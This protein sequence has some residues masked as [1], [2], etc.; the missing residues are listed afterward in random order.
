VQIRHVRGVRILFASL[1]VVLA[2]TG[3]VR[4]SDDGAALYDR[5]CLACHGAKG[6]G[7]GPAAAWLWPRPRDLT[8]GERKWQD[9]DATIRWGVTGAMPGFGV[10]LDDK[11]IAALV[12]VV[13]GFAGGAP[14]KPARPKAAPAGTGDAARGQALWAEAGCTSCHGADG[15]GETAAAPY[16]LTAVPPRRPHPPGGELDATAQSIAWGVGGTAMPAYDGALPDADLLALAAYVR[17]IQPTSAPAAPGRIDPEAIAADRAGTL[18]RAGYR[19]GDA[20]DPDY[21]VWGIAIAPQG[22][23]PASLSPA[24][25]NLSA[26]RCARCHASQYRDWSGTI[27]AQAMSVGMRAQLSRVT[28]PESLTSCLRCHSPLAEQQPTDAGYD[29]ALQDEGI[30]C[31]SCHVRGWTRHGPTTVSAS[32]LSLPGYP[33]QPLA[34]YERS[35]FCL[36]C[37]QL[38]PRSS[39]EGRPLLDTYREWLTG[40]YMPRG[41]QCQHCHMPNREHTW[42]GIHDP[43]TFR[44]GYRLETIA[45]RGKTGVVSVRARIWNVGAGHLLPTTPTPAAWLEIELVD[46]AGKPVAGARATK[47]IGRDIAPKKGGGWIEKEDTRIAPGAW[48]EVAAGWKNGRVAEA[49]HVKVTVRVHPDDYYERLYRARLKAELTDAARADY[50]GALE[51]SMASRYVAE[52][53]LVELD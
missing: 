15:K 40:P 43:D 53:V 29:L 33:T 41:V 51:R 47:R 21:V 39:V 30:T 32:L 17:S 6:D 19:P 1:G 14:K 23:P 4:A 46:A 44:Q 48:L 31:A 27:H 35:D 22:E 25:A 45:A 26:K 37:H 42:K 18:T 10:A 52:E 2:L 12:A 34:L 28:K 16:D 11:E 13:H 20:G 38:Q 50:E 49:T 9:L 36:P 3:V 7:N 5:L 24:Q 8:S